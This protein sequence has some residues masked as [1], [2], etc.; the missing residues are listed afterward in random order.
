MGTPGYYAEFSVYN[1]SSQYCST[2][3]HGGG[4]SNSITLAGDHTWADPCA[5][6][7]RL[8]G[9]AKE[10]L[11]LYMRWRNSRS[12]RA[13]FMWFPVHLTTV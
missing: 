1:T 3:A 7:E 10:R 5:R 6:C 2:T 8:R 12:E 9:C 11:L 4:T 13:R